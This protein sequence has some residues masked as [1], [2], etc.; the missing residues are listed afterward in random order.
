MG[1]A[2]GKPAKDVRDG[3]PHLPYA[4]ATAALAGFDRDN[5]MVIHSIN[6]ASFF[7]SAVAFLVSRPRCGTAFTTILF[8]GLTAPPVP[9]A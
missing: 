3:D 6:I 2:G 7:V 4:S 5:V 8:L 9:A 1:L